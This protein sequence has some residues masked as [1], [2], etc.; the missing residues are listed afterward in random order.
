[1]CCLEKEAARLR[2]LR[3]GSTDT[4]TMQWQP[5]LHHSDDGRDLAAISIFTRAR[6]NY[7]LSTGTLA[8]T[9]GLRDLL[10]VHVARCQLQP[11]ARMPCFRPRESRP[12][13][14]WTSKPATKPHELQGHSSFPVVINLAYRMIPILCSCLRHHHVVFQNP[15]L[16]Y[17]ED[18]GFHL[19]P[20]IKPFLRPRSTITGSCTMSFPCQ[21]LTESQTGE[22]LGK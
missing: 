22:R 16:S 6:L 2:W 20:L 12:H 19:V 10:T 7:N 1:M 21:P 8:A 17:E 5:P 13:L 4:A 18:N 14:A 11:A 9:N 15:S 3:P